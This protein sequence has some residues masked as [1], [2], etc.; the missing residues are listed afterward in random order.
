MTKS[1]HGYGHP[2]NYGGKPVAKYVEIFVDMA[3]RLPKGLGVT[4]LFGGVGTLA[5]ALW[6]VLE[7]S[8]WRSIEIDPQ[9]VKQYGEPRAT[10]VQG[11]AFEVSDFDELVLIDPHKGTLNAIIKGDDWRTLL[12]NICVSPAKYILMQEY[13]AYWCH[14]PNQKT[15]YTELF[16]GPVDRQNYRD[17]F[18]QYMENAYNFKVVD[19]R[20]GL[21]SCYYLM[22][23]K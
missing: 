6:P 19:H 3:R 8:R 15:L 17:K 11:D 5:T 22:E 23:A 20:I 16:G 1:E 9:C 4:D 7:P 14:L 10:V 21:G 13:G 12:H 18:T 2:F